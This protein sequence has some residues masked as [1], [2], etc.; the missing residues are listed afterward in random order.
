M[1]LVEPPPRRLYLLAFPVGHAYLW[2]APDGLTLIDTGMPGSAP[3]I[4]EAVT[5][6][7]HTRHDLR[8]IL[9]THAHVDHVGRRRPR[10]LGRRPSW[11]HTT[12]TPPSSVALA[13]RH[14][15]AEWEQHLYDQIHADLPADPPPPALVDPRTARRR[16]HHP[17]RRCRGR[18]RRRA[19]P[20]PGQRGVPPAPP[21]A[22]PVTAIRSPAPPTAPSCSACSTR[23]VPRRLLPAPPG[24]PPPG[25]R[26]LRP[27]HPHRP[28]RHN[29]GHR[30]NPATDTAR[31]RPQQVVQARGIVGCGEWD[32]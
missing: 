19:G 10:R 3:R 7:G 9:L 32:G 6:L 29:P 20:H 18:R 22:R 24:R 13:S 11:P 27:R 8:Q 25:H 15:L 12:T 21:P 5:A 4:A 30:R 17:R 16:H 14:Q 26:L 31:D 2:R 1:D 23:S 28:H